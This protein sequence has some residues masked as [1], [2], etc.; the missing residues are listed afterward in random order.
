MGENKR[1]FSN[2][3]GDLGFFLGNGSDKDN[4]KKAVN[5]EKEEPNDIFNLTLEQAS[6]GEKLES[7]GG[8]E[9]T[10]PL[11]TSNYEDISNLV[12]DDGMSSIFDMIRASRQNLDNAKMVT[13]SEIVHTREATEYEK[14]QQQKSDKM[15][16]EGSEI[17]KEYV[18][19]GLKKLEETGPDAKKVRSYKNQ[20]VYYKSKFAKA[21]ESE[22]NPVK[23]FVIMAIIAVAVGIFGGVQANSYFVMQGGKA[24]GVLKCAFS[25]ILSADSMS[26]D[27]TPFYV[28]IFFGA[29]AIWFSAIAVILMFSYFNKKTMKKSRVGHEHGNAKLMDSKSFEKY[30]NRFMEG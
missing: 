20:A 29:F 26:T 11:D 9:V 1:D 21:Q 12:E 15:V 14:L 8:L 4:S 2:G 28:D 27:L 7:S 5:I 19:E 17:I 18:D 3:D 25:W 30:K 22:E 13:N 10:I 6:G 16:I 24:Q 23:G